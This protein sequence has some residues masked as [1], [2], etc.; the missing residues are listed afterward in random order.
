MSDVNS[1]YANGAGSLASLFAGQN[2]A[3]SQA[4]AAANLAYTQQQTAHNSAMSP[5]EQQFK[6]AQLAQSQAQLPGI[7]GQSKSAAAQGEEDTQLL[8][9]KV[10]TKLDAYKTQL[11]D[12]GMKR[13]ADDGERLLQVSKII[14]Q[15]PPNMRKQAF[16]EAIKGYGGTADSPMIQG[17]LQA[18]DGEFLKAVDVVG[19]GMAMSGRKYLQESAL[20]YSENQ[21]QERVN[22]ANN[23]SREKIAMAQIEGKLQVA[24][25]K[26]STAMQYMSPD[27]RFTWLNA[28]PEDQLTEDQRTEKN[29]LLKFILSAKAAGANGTTAQ[30]LQGADIQTQQQTAEKTADTIAPPGKG[31]A[32]AQSAPT[33]IA[34]F[35]KSQGMPYDPDKFHYRINPSTNKLERKAK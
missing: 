12:N 13:L 19:Q 4:Q 16:Q 23:T 32:P 31:S 5:L 24:E 15:Y 35:A 9:S 2:Q 1:L 11:G 6:Q 33:D 18:P 3:S 30:L 10:A 28:I 21:S 7:V 34:A 25:K 14:E 22:T 29:R 27:K 8:A 17:L 26:A 20:K